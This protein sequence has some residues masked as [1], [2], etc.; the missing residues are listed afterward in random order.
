MKKNIIIGIICTVGVLILIAGGL[1]LFQ[2][3]QERENDDS[4]ISSETENDSES[5]EQSETDDEAGGTQNAAA[6]SDDADGLP[7][8]IIEDDG[9]VVSEP[10][11]SN[12]SNGNNSESVVP[13]NGNEL[14]VDWID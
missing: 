14:P 12:G 6:Q 3:T 11:G 13:D 2:G 10:N 7:I 1:H 4:M 9:S 8:D 5:D